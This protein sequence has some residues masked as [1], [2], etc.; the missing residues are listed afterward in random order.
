MEFIKFPT[1]LCVPIY[2]DQQIVFDLLAMLDN[3]FSQVNTVNTSITGTKT[4]DSKKGASLSGSAF[5]LFN[6]SINR[7]KC[8]TNSAIDNEQQTMTKTHT[9]SSMFSILRR[10]LRYKKFIS[11]M[12]TMDDINNLKC[13]DFVEFRSK[14][15]PNPLMDSFNRMREVSKLCI[16]YSEG[17]TKK[18]TEERRVE[19]PQEKDQNRRKNKQNVPNNQTDV[20]TQ[21]NQND[22]S[23][24]QW[25]YEL[26]D[27]LLN[28]NSTEI[29]GN[30][31]DQP[32]V[33]V[34][35]SAKVNCFVNQDTSIVMNG[36]FSVFGKVT[37]VISCDS[38]DTIDLLQKTT[39][40]SF[41]E[42]VINMF[43]DAFSKVP[44]NAIIFPEIT[45]K[46]KGPAIQILPIAIFI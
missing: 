23:L 37:Q 44:N 40:K 16:K 19:S 8:E 11:P 46:I 12:D 28:S 35:L 29:I 25:I 33:K 15:T 20:A 10:T 18:K 5:N 22:V 1:D 27:D 38:K 42:E 30:I 34:D 9:T 39:L 7:D 3:G 24:F 17:V 13:G 36:E 14:L 45:T 4:D 31:F 26:S 6:F 21:E 43:T 2:L 41:G 32:Q